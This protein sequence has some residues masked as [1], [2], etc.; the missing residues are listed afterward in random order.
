MTAGLSIGC[1]PDSFQAWFPAAIAADVTL[2]NARLSLR[3]F[4]G[5]I[6]LQL[7]SIEQIS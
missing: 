5:K 3:V 2:A 1:N 7:Q 6:F 4:Q